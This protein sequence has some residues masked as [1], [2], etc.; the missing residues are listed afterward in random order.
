MPPT[1]RRPQ[2]QEVLGCVKILF[3]R[4]IFIRFYLRSASQ[5]L[6]KKHVNCKTSINNFFVY[7]IFDSYKRL[8][9]I[10]SI[11]NNYFNFFFIM[12]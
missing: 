1:T 8:K 7:S 9:L 2:R 12:H 5:T 10:L 3:N 4:R 11:L 6:K